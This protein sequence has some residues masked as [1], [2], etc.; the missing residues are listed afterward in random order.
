MFSRDEEKEGFIDRHQLWPFYR[1]RRYNEETMEAVREVWREI[2]EGYTID[3]YPEP[4]VSRNLHK[5]ENVKYK[6]VEKPK[7]IRGRERMA[8]RGYDLDDLDYVIDT[9]CR[10]YELPRSFRNHKLKGDLKGYMECHVAY[11]WVLIY[12]YKKRERQLILY[13]VDTGTHEDVFQ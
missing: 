10:G 13:A 1:R 12:Q 7:Y 6:L 3:D 11:D 8:E 5:R 2:E 4:R 9:L